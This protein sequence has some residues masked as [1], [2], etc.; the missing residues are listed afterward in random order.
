M[1]KNFKTN[2]FSVV[3]V[4]V[5]MLMVFQITKVSAQVLTRALGYEETMEMFLTFPFEDEGVIYEQPEIDFERVLKE[6]KQDGRQIPRFAVD[7]AVNYGIEDGIWIENEEYAIWKIT[8]KSQKASSMQVMFESLELPKLAEMYIYSKESKIIQGPI[9]QEVVTKGIYTS[10]VIEKSGEIQIAILCRKDDMKL[11]FKI[12]RIAQGLKLNGNRAWGSGGDCNFDVNCVIGAAWTLQRDAV[13]LIFE[14]MNGIC[15][16]SLI[17]NQCQDLTPNFLTAFHCLDFNLDQTLSSGEISAVSNWVFRFNY[18]STS[19]T[20]PGNTGGPEPNST[21]WI[22]RSGATLRTSGSATDF[23][24][25]LLNGGTI[26]INSNE[27]SLALAGWDR[28]TTTPTSGFG[29]HH[30]LA[31]A[32]KISFSTGPITTTGLQ[33]NPGTSCWRINITGSGAFEEGSSGSPLFNQVGRIVGNANSATAGGCSPSTRFVNFG[34]FDMSWTA[35]ISGFLGGTTPPMTL[36]GIRVPSLTPSQSN[37]TYDLICT[38]NKTITLINPIPSRTLTWSVTNPALFATTGGATTSG[39]TVNAI[40]RAASSTTTGSSVLT[41][42]LTAAGCTPIT[43]TR[44]LWV[45]VPTNPTTNPPN[46]YYQLNMGSS[47]SAYITSSNG[48]TNFLGTWTK[49]GNVNIQHTSAYTNYITP[50]APGNGYVYVKTSNV[51]GLSSQSVINYYIPSMM[52][53]FP[54][55][56]SKEEKVKIEWSEDGTDN[57][58]KLA[59]VNQMGNVVANLSVESISSEIDISNLSPGLYLFKFTDEKGYTTIKKLIVK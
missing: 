50:T 59:I 52:K 56:V 8:F 54:S 13:G 29:I 32:K 58:Y 43:I 14:G 5:L 53:V 39:S 42:T 1:K 12:T 51:C 41:F 48:S 40:L 9:N 37:T 17:N 10:D 7:Y 11:N 57:N 6:D 47:A 49:S 23:A 36:N 20:C 22:T 25:L 27:T 2:G 3:S 16:G 55:V 28:S 45:G 30:P 31:D 35:G 24:L 18:Q 4:L 44:N 46:G 38:T 19:P 34:K 15:S 21:T 33:N 26:G